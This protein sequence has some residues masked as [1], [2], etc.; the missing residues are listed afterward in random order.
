MDNNSIP[1]WLPTT[2]FF[3]GVAILIAVVILVFKFDSPN[4]LQITTIRTI[5]ALAGAAFAMAFTGFL[6]L[7]LSLPGSGFIVAGGSLGVF[8]VLYFFVPAVIGEGPTNKTEEIYADLYD[9]SKDLLYV[10]QPSEGNTFG[11]SLLCVEEM[12][13]QQIIPMGLAKII[14]SP[15]PNFPKP[16]VTLKLT[17][18]GKKVRSR[19]AQTRGTLP[20]KIPCSS[21]DKGN[22]AL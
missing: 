12:A 15:D 20:P 3:I 18:L 11:P 7:R 8:V 14:D 5:T 16:N 1:T 22:K 13:K 17:D 19:I 21:L 9:I 10:L 2:A 6:S 4:S